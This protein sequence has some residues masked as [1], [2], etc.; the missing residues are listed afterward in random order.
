MIRVDDINGRLRYVSGGASWDAAGTQ[1][2][3]NNDDTALAA[4]LQNDFGSEDLT[5]D[6]IAATSVAD[7]TFFVNKKRKVERDEVTPSNSRPHE[8]MFYLKKTDYNK[9]YKCSVGGLFSGSWHT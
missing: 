8:G 3:T 7:Y 1:I 4:Y 6:D 9:T 2:A 5:R